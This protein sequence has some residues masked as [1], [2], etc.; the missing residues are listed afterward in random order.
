M[1]IKTPPAPGLVPD[2]T[3]SA[4]ALPPLPATD[5]PLAAQRLRLG[6]FNVKYS[7]NLGD[8]LLSECLEGALVRC[9][10]GRATSI[11]LA[12]RTAYSEGSS[13]RARTMRLLHALPGPLRAQAVRLPLFLAGQRHWSPH[14]RERLRGCD[15]VV[16]GGGNLLADMDLNFPT[17]IAR[18]VEAARQAGLPVFLYGVGVSHGWSR[19]GRTLLHKALGSGTVRAVFVRDEAS[20][21]AWDELAGEAFAL[22]ARVVRDPGLLAARHYGLRIGSRQTTDGTAPAIFGASASPC[23]PTAAPRIGLNIMSALAVRYHGG[24][25]MDEDALDVW[26]RDLARQLLNQGCHLTLFSNGSPEDRAALARLQAPIAALAG[27]DRLAF[28]AI[29]TPGDLVRCVAGLDALV[30]F[31]MH[32]IIAAY[33]CAVPFLAL[34]WDRKLASFVESVNCAQWFAAA[35]Q[36]PPSQAAQQVLG[37]LREGIAPS[38]RDA[39]LEEAMDGVRALYRAMHEVVYPGAPA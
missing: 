30:A 15:A 34:A 3:A 11:D 13:T 35:H 7:P 33:S 4:G 23:D 24:Q 18:A 32:A 17:K 21:Q 31:R 28:P 37:A 2:P 12:A 9:G 38:A 26:Y 39:V 20:R 16:L 8:G 36:T 14:Y 25:D 6:L 27:P 5:H 1:L 22:P 10:A 19:R 29:A